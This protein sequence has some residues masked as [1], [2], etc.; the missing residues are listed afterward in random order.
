MSQST[1]HSMH[2]LDEVFARLS[3]SSFRSR[4][5]LKHKERDYLQRKGMRVILKHAA[6]FIEQR[7]ASAYPAKDGKQ[8]P[9]GGHPVFIAQHATG[10]CCRNCLLKWH[11]L[12]KGRAL[13]AE[14]QQYIAD[15]IERWLIHENTNQ[16]TGGIL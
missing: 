1:K 3:K 10:T 8:T 5:Y 4:F 11:G 14:E 2:N 9:W 6:N 16:H 7:L 13:D 15:V 12:P